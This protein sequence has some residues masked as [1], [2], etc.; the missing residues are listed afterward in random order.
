MCTHTVRHDDLTNNFY[1]QLSIFERTCDFNP[2]TLSSHP[3]LIRRAYSV[4]RKRNILIL[5]YHRVFDININ[6]IILKYINRI[7]RP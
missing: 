7:T 1:I 2:L 5:F 3:E 4:Y 6:K